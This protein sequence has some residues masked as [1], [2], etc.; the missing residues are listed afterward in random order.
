MDAAEL[1]HR[2]QLEPL[3][4]EG[5]LFRRTYADERS[6]AI[7]YLLA[8]GDFS[9][10]HRLPGPEL[11]HFHAGAPLDV[12]LLHPGGA[13]ETAVLDPLQRPQLA[14]PAGVWQGARS[15]G[16]WT[17]TGTTMAPPYRDEDIEFGDRAELTRGWSAYADL[18][19]SL[20]R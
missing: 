1:A 19:R 16:E 7:L 13:A 5:G 20:T 9:A 17:L 4:G 10:L 18:I 12:L 3:P 14:V 15:T 8:A 11:W 6:S 2:L